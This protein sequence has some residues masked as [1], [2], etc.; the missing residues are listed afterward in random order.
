MLLKIYAR[1]QHYEWSVSVSE[2]G[3]EN[4]INE[5]MYRNIC[6]ETFYLTPF[7]SIRPSS[8]AFSGV[9][10]IIFLYIKE[11]DLENYLHKLCVWIRNFQQVYRKHTFH[12]SANAVTTTRRQVRDEQSIGRRKHTCK[13]SEAKRR[14]VA[15]RGACVGT[16]QQTTLTTSHSQT[17][18]G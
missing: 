7:F 6:M 3:Y 16:R 2:I 12:L 17:T 1:K 14:G 9:E 18:V 11:K 10:S 5:F 4:T 15:R 8:S 13:V